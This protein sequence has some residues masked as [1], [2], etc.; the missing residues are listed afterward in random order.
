MVFLDIYYK[1][2]IV[3]Y[4]YSHGDAKHSVGNK[5]LIILQ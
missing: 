5:V 4:K 2:Q 3:S 1:E